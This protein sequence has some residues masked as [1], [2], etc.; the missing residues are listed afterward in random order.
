MGDRGNIGIRQPDE[1]ATIYFY[2]HWS[3]S[4]VPTILAEGLR[5]AKEGGRLTDPSYATRIIFDTLTGQDNGT[6]G[7]GICIGSPC[8]NEHEIPYV[9]WDDH[10]KEPTIHYSCGE[11][12]PT[13]WI[14]A[15]GEAR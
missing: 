3:G 13:M 9:I 14:E 5:K 1:Q 12:T 8:D 2:T 6:T 15:F 11:F 7:F 4:Y 10:A